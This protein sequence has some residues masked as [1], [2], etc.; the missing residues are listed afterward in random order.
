LIL[1]VFTVTLLPHRHFN[2]PAPTLQFLHRQTKLASPREPDCSFISYIASSDIFNYD[3]NPY[4]WP[5]SGLINAPALCCRK[6]LLPALAT[7][8]YMTVHSNP[9]AMRLPT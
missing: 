7:K 9:I 6:L 2:L 5:D 4:V 8:T 3:Q 1:A